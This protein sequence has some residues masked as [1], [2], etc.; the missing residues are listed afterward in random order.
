MTTRTKT[1]RRRPSFTRPLVAAAMLAIGLSLRTNVAGRAETMPADVRNAFAKVQ[2]DG[3]PYN[4]FYNYYVA[5]HAVV[6]NGRVFTAHQ[7]GQGRPVVMAYDVAERRWDGPVV[8][9][10]EGL[11]SDT[12][13]NPSLAIDGDGYLHLFFGCHGRRMLHVRSTRPHDIHQWSDAPS[14]TPRATYPE[15]MR[16][17][18]GRIFLFY[19]AGGHPEPW[20]L[21]IS[22]D[23]AATWSEAEKIVELRTDAAERRTAAYCAFVP[24][25]GGKSVHCFFVYKDDDPRGNGRK[26]LGL[27][28]AVYRYNVYY[29]F[30]DASG[31]WLGADGQL[32][33]LPVSK[34]EADAHGLVHDTG[35]S[36]AGLKR[37]VIDENDRP[38]LRFSEGVTDWKNHKTIVR[39]VY[40]Y[41]TPAGGKWHVTQR[42]AQDWPEAV[43]RTIVT[44]GPAAYG[45]ECPNPWFIHHK[46]GSDADPSATYIWLG[47]IDDGYAARDGGPATS[48]GDQ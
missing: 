46:M 33:K 10:D 13:G 34:R 3:K 41:A 24:G 30:R 8:A 9:S 16:M 18:D 27:H 1:R 37:I 22:S 43:R 21:R 19:R 23:N 28:E 39:P 4:T 14:P 7:N 40:R 25:A 36:F 17:A 26:Y 31:R 38:Y 15:S 2:R 6:E 35:E 11:G 44:P 5:P 42:S 29:I 12:H 20:S 47:H 45:E 48:P 32:L